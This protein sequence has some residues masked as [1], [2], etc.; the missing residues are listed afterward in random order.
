MRFA[1]TG[2]VLGAVSAGLVLGGA[3]AI[4]A[5]DDA[6][7]EKVTRGIWLGTVAVGPPIIALSAHLARKASSFASPTSKSVRRL[8]WLAYGLAVSDG[9]LLWASAF[10]GLPRTDLLTVGAGAFAVVALLPHALDAFTAGRAIRLRRFLRRVDASATGLE[11][12][13]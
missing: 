2:A 4:A 3:I 9:A 7:S 13:F 1:Y 5:I 8:G 11:L 6:G 10:S 12:R